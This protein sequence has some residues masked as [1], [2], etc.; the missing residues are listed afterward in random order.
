MQLNRLIF[1][2][3][4]ISGQYFSPT[5]ICA[6]PI[7]IQLI[8]STN[9]LK[10]TN[11]CLDLWRGKRYYVFMVVEAMTKKCC[12]YCNVD[13]SQLF[14]R[15][16]IFKCQLCIL[17]SLKS[18]KLAINWITSCK[19]E[20]NAALYNTTKCILFYSSGRRPDCRIVAFFCVHQNLKLLSK[21]VT[22]HTGN[23]HFRITLPILFRLHQCILI[24]IYT[25]VT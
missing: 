17:G 24:V 21:H 23:S 5:L 22:Q 7:Q 4:S 19:Y 6:A 20:I 25:Y 18:G 3:K 10:K 16:K 8:Y 2:I 12:E 15:D 11:L 1:G 13:D 9:N 14:H